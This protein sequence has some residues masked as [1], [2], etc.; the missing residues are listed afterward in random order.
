MTP[1][2]LRAVA[3]ILEAEGGATVTDDV[4]DPG[5]LTKWGISKRSYPDLDIRNLTREQAVDIYHRD[6]WLPVRADELPQALALA[7]FDCAVNQGVA[8]A[9]KLLQ[10]ACDVPQDG[11]IGPVTVRASRRPD[12]L[13]RFTAARVIR[14]FGTRNFDKFGFGWITRA[15]QSALEASK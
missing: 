3:V 10:R 5:G 11:R 7:V 4:D 9:G 6:F 14:Y 12:A 1:A 8:V 13:A 15:V 2:F